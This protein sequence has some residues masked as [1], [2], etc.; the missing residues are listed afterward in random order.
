[1]AMLSQNRTDLSGQKIGNYEL[2]ERL[3]TRPVSDFYIGRDAKLD[4]P[5]FI[6]ILQTKEEQ[7]SNLVERFQRRTETVSQI[8]NSNIAPVIDAGVTEDGYPFAI[9]EFISGDWLSNKLADWEEEEYILPVDEALLLARQIAVGISAAHSVGLIDSELRPDNILILEADSTPVLLDLVVPVTARARDSVLTNGHSESLDYASPEEIE[10]KAISRRSN[11]YSLGIIIYELLTGHRPRLP[12]SS[13]DIFERSTMPKE[14]PLEEERQ[15]LS[16]ETYRLVRS[17]LWRQ[18]WSRFESTDELISAIDTAILAEQS[19]PKATLWTSKRRRWLYVAVPVIALL[20]IVF[21]LVLVWSQF[22]N[23][24]Q[25]ADGSPTSTIDPENDNS[26]SGLI[27]GINTPGPT[28]TLT[29]EAPPTLD[30]E[31]TIPV[32]GPLADQSFSA[33]EIIDFA[34]IWLTLPNEN[35]VFAVYIIAEDNGGES[36]LAG[37]VTEP[38]N[39]SL[40]LLEKSS[41]DIGIGPG[42]YLWQVRLEDKVSGELVVESDPRRFIIIEELTPTPTQIPATPTPSATATESL[43]TATP[44]EE[45]CVPTAPPGWISHQVQLGESPSIFGQRAN[46]RVQDIL[47][48][49][50]LSP[51]AVLSVGQLLYIPPPLATNTPTPGPIRT[52]IIDQGTADGGNTGGGNSGGGGGGGDNPTSQPTDPPEPTDQPTSPPVIPP[53]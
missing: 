1:M 46:V 17:C 23:A 7:D 47:D 14:V 53:S 40:F 26:N 24:Q 32:F 30:A 38:D 34:W 9:S 19:L 52:P 15:G 39:A 41:K 20:F 51:G 6:E 5:V 44:T 22:A 8:K 25:G 36:I 10:G 45:F 33:A 13:W 16:G 27:A 3:K 43:P 42:S 21:G 49:N 37:T 48:V 2:E 35:E 18:E 4:R 11:I 50:C 28:P 12:T 31:V 29:R